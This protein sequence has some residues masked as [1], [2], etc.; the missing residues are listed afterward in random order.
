M[1][2]LSVLPTASRST[3]SGAGAA[4]GRI[5]TRRIAERFVQALHR[6][7]FLMERLLALPRLHGDDVE[8]VFEAEKVPGVAG[9]EPRAVR[10]G[11]RGDQQIHGSSAGRAANGDHPG[12]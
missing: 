6:R 9:V 12:R 7:Q 5:G 8:H 1:I 3:P 11:R 4:R 10:M 2:N